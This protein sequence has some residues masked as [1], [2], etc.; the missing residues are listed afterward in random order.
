MLKI[1]L[2]LTPKETYAVYEVVEKGFTRIDFV[3]DNG[4]F[5]VDVDK[6]RYSQVHKR[7]TYTYGDHSIY[8]DYL[9]VK[10]T[11][12]RANMPNAIRDTTELRDGIYVRTQ[13]AENTKLGYVRDCVLH[14]GI[15]WESTLQMPG[16]AITSE[17]NQY[18]YGVKLDPQNFSMYE[19]KGLTSATVDSS[20]S[21]VFYTIEQ[22]R[23]R[24]DIEHLYQKDFAC[25]TNLFIARA[26]LD[27]FKRNPYPIKGF[28]TETTGLDVTIYG[29]DKLVGII[30]GHDKDT[31]TYFPFRHTGDF[32][33]PMSFL[34]ELMEVVIAQQGRLVAHNKKFDRQVML[35]EGYDVRIKWDTL[36]I[37][38]VRNPV[39]GRGV[40]GLKPLMYEVNGKTYLE[41]NNIYVDPRTIDFSVLPVELLTPYACP[42]GTN[43]IE[44]FEWE[45]KRVPKY[46]WKLVELEC[47]LA[48][49]K[50]DQEYYGTRVDTRMYERQYKNCNYILELLVKAF[51]ILTK[52]DGNI[53]SPDVLRDLLYNKMRCDVL[54]RT[55]TG[56]PSTASQAVKKLGALKA[57]VPGQNPG[58]LVDLY[59]DVIIKGEDLAKS[60]YP[61]LLILSKYRE[62]Q[63]LVTA[64][65]AR[66]ER[67][68]KTGRVFFW[69]NQN[70]AATGR[71]SSPMHQLPPQL[72]KVILSDADDR[73]FWGPDYSQVEL[74]MIA[75]LAGET[76]LIELASDPTNDIHRVIGSLI[77]G[78]EMWAIT[79]EERS[80]GKRRN[81]GVIYLISARGLAG[82]LYGPGYTEE[83]VEF[84]QQQ[85]N[86]FYKR[87]K[88]IDRFIKQNAQKVEKQGYM[89]TAWFKRVRLFNEVFDPNLEPRK[90]ASIK[91]MANNIP[92]Q[93]TAADL[94]KLAEVLMYNYI[95]EKGWNKLVD[96]FPMVRIMLSIHDEI[97]ISA[98]E[99]IPVEEIAEMITKCMEIPVEDAPPFFAQPA[100]MPNWG[101]HNNDS[102]PMPIP[103][104]DNIIKQYHETGVSQFKRS[105]FKLIVP[106]SVAQEIS[107]S[108]IGKVQDLVNKYI[109]TCE[110]VYDYGD[111]VRECTLDHK[112]DALRSYIESG[113]TKYTIDNY[114]DLI[115]QYR[116]GT[117]HDYMTGLIA[118]YGTDYKVVGE[119]VRHP[120]LTHDLLAKY[121]KQLKGK[122]LDHVDAITEAARLYIEDMLNDA[123]E[124]KSFVY[125]PANEN[126][127]LRGNEMFTTGLEALVNLDANGD[128][129]YADD[130]DEDS[131]PD[132]YD[133]TDDE[134]QDFENFVSGDVNYVWE[135]NDFITFDVQDF[136]EDDINKVLSYIFNH[137]DDKGF[138]KTYL[139]Y[140][141]KLV[142]TG[143]RVEKMD[144]E[145][146]NAL[147]KDLQRDKEIS[148]V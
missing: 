138:Y 71:Q 48:D 88:R 90:R 38:I 91:R 84:C 22:L 79:P 65:Y 122:G 23:R 89:E 134:A 32:N 139:I 58:D 63:K 62:Y 45:L 114:V 44:L 127:S 55:K 76:S 99:S 87:F 33:L 28:D 5:Q 24:Y 39:V 43:V 101:E 2:F 78:K 102:L 11:L 86:D 123:H 82:Q 68:M 74:R 115:N 131:L 29:E 104:R 16:Y 50:A 80:V 3:A 12:E 34:P 98:H 95:R 56:L 49:L 108:D 61:A 97:I 146:A 126:I 41:L 26:R 8:D 67:T 129:I 77:T 130:N 36:Q 81:F 21:S 51:R 141:G 20:N 121:N 147:L 75:Y 107:N 60:K 124:T 103:F 73:D 19:S 70:G 83:Q 31:A 93:G 14:N 133:M 132:G 140:E 109:D 35:K 1:G 110:L 42:D 57:K 128:V 69:V 143:I 25:A 54:L 59:G 145:E 92:V 64:F 120:V 144:T 112:K 10:E 7:K 105:Y 4:R 37:D 46:L 15:L 94:M 72:K 116:D 27:A 111:Y 53:N 100:R 148:N 125:V 113:F 30:L 142:D 85:L 6:V 66:F 18:E 96:G 136:H 135:L 119:H 117:L 47:D 40:H 52:E 17:I 13:H 106:D 9:R 137:K 118:E